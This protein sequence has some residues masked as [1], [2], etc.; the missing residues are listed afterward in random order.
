MAQRVLDR[1]LYNNSMPTTLPSSTDEKLN[2]ILEHLHNLDR[3]DRLRM[4]GG[5]FRSLLSIIPFLIFLYSGWYLY[6]HGAEIISQVTQEAAKQ[7]AIATKSTSQDAVKQ[8]QKY[9]QQQ[10]PK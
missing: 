5:F 8:V 9:L 7:A 3:R 1:I 10:L 2:A 4:W 6:Q